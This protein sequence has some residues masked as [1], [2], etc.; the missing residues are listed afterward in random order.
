MKSVYFILSLLMLSGY[1]IAIE[2][3]LNMT[4]RVNI[5]CHLKFMMKPLVRFLVTSQ[6]LSFFLTDQVFPRDQYIFPLEKKA[7]KDG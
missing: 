3:R 7:T 6:A 5:P 2:D 1:L 4:L